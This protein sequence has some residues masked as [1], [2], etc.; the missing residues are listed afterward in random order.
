MPIEKRVLCVLQVRI[1]LELEPMVFV[2]TELLAADS[3][4]HLSK[5]TVIQRGSVLLGGSVWG[6]DCILNRTDLRAPAARALT[7]A[8]VSRVTRDSLLGIMNE[9]IS[10]V[11][12]SGDPIQ[13][14]KYPIAAHKLHWTKI[15][16]GLRREGKRMAEEARRR[17]GGSTG[18]RVL[19]WSEMLANIGNMEAV[20]PQELAA[21][22]AAA[23]QLA[24]LERKK[25]KRRSISPKGRPPS[26]GSSGS[27]WTVDSENKEADV[28]AE[29]APV[30]AA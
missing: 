29:G 24:K 4:Y 15:K 13:V 10:G 27:R 21:A 25:S 3:M 11:D 1:A 2:P 30:A 28:T 5:G 20:D 19:N 14:P 17:E 7:Y 12:S 23:A 18:A 6:E 9:E 26:R 16:L 22:E 8:D